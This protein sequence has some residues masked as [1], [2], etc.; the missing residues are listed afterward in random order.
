MAKRRSPNSHGPS[1]IW[2][3]ATTLAAISEARS[4]LALRL[5][6]LR[7]EAGLTQESAAERAGIHSKHL[8][9]L[10]RGV[11]NATL[12]TLCAI[13]LGLGVSLET[14]F[15]SA[16]TSPSRKLE[17]TAAKPTRRAPPTDRTR[18]HRITKLRR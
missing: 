18:A 13:S 16:P 12:G 7:H 2:S 8:Q 4:K 3:R 5:R 14:L 15:S 17:P 9:R 10:E 11:E 1:E 6:A